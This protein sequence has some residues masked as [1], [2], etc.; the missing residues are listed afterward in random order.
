MALLTSLKYRYFHIVMTIAN[1]RLVSVN[2]RT[3][4]WVSGTLREKPLHHG[5]E[6]DVQL[7]QHPDR[8]ALIHRQLGD[9]LSQLR[10]D[11]HTGGTGSDDCRP[12]AG[13]RKAVIPGGGVQDASG[14]RLD[15]GDIRRARLAQEAGRG[16]QEL[17]AQRLTTG[18][19]NPPDLSIVVPPGA[20]NG[21]VEPHE[22]AHVVLIG[23]MLGVALQFGAG[24]IQPRPVRVRLKPVGERGRRLID[25]KTRIVV[26]VPRST[27]VV[28][29]IDDQDVVIA[30]A[31]ELDCRADSAETRPDDDY[32]ELLLPISIR[33]YL[34]SYR[35]E[36]LSAD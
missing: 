29:A 35:D 1:S 8:R 16:D 25:S 11:L 27:Q 36:R 26:D 9:F 18:N 15:T 30:Q 12:A 28:L 34:P 32:V 31:A 2:Q 5:R 22:A 17:R 14:E 3:V 33:R 23:H 7:G 13:K 20:F 6:P 21:G 4:R 24:R 19:G 10:N